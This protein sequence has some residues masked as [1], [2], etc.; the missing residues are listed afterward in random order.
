MF[1]AVRKFIH[2]SENQPQK[3][4]RILRCN[5]DLWKIFSH[6]EPTK[7]YTFTKPP[8]PRFLLRKKNIFLILTIKC[9][10]FLRCYNFK[11]WLILL[12][13]IFRIFSFRFL[14]VPI[15]KKNIMEKIVTKNVF[16][17]YFKKLI[18]KFVSDKP[19]V[20]L[21]LK[22][23]KMFNICIRCIHSGELGK[24]PQLIWNL[25]WVSHF[26]ILYEISLFCFRQ[27]AERRKKTF[28][29]WSKM[30]KF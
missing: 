13:K 15:D 5:N 1:E 2:G 21:V 10:F 27:M 29:V 18:A 8:H 12:Q 26:E 3:P 20:P 11:N 24:F 4:W 22:N 16:G 30:G 7:F 14:S 17:K 19:I 25:W 6:F 9:F 28:I 23:I